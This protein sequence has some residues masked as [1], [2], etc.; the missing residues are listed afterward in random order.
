MSVAGMLGPRN[1]EGLTAV[2][3]QRPKTCCTQLA[4]AQGTK[5]IYCFSSSW[6]VLKVQCPMAIRLTGRSINCLIYVSTDQ[7]RLLC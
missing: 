7:M 2:R 3:V 5:K 6:K 1:T 4:V